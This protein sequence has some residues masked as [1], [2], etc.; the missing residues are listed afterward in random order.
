MGEDPGWPPGAHK[1]ITEEENLNSDKETRVALVRVVLAL[2]WVV[3]VVL[4]EVPGKKTSTPETDLGFSNF[5]YPATW[6]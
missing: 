1:Q 4:F 6:V 3:L 2:V 5:C